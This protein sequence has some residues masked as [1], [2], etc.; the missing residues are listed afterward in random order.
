MPLTIQYCS[1]LHL[2]FVH[3]EKFMQKYPL[4][5]KGDILLLAG[6]IVPFAEIDKH[7]Y[8]FDFVA[9]NYAAV[10]WVPGNHEYYNA[11]IAERSG[12][13]REKI[14]DNVFLLNNTTVP[15]AGDTELVCTTLW[16]KINPAD[17][18]EVVRAM[19]DFHVITNNG[20][21]FTIND[22]NRLHAESLSY[23]TGALATGTAKHKIVMSHHI[24]TYMHYPPKYKGD[25]LSQAFASEQ[26]E[27]IEQAGVHSWIFGH[28][29]CNIPEFKIGG[30]HMLT[31]QLGYVKYGENKGFSRGRVVVVERG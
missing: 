7:H 24:P 4:E 26:F 21:R 12:A 18:W 14:R 29:H 3:N 11:D 30:T 1:D 23:L 9:D 25:L 22:F 2:E 16:S 6:D 8:F 19:S 28:H 20:H 10:Y 31:N 27:L 5:V 13:F 15:L 17:E